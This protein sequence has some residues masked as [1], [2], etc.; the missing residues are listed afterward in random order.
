MKYNLLTK[1]YT[2]EERVPYEYHREQ[3]TGNSII[4]KDGISLVLCEYKSNS[5]ID[6]RNQAEILEK[7]GEVESIDVMVNATKL[8]TFILE[9]PDVY[10]RVKAQL[11]RLNYD[12]KISTLG[13]Y[14]SFKLKS[15]KDLDT[16]ISKA[17]FVINAEIMKK[18]Q[19]ISR[20]GMI[21]VFDELIEPDWYPLV[22]DKIRSIV[23]IERL[24]KPNNFEV[25]S[26]N[27]REITVSH[28]DSNRIIK[29]LSKITG[30]PIVQIGFITLVNASYDDVK[31]NIKVNREECANE[32]VY[33][34]AQKRYNIDPLLYLKCYRDI[35]SVDKHIDNIL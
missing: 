15:S 11:E 28:V 10:N 24:K 12:I 17:M 6:I 3:S 20:R 9:I 34:L 22:I 14:I 26:E 25:E 7:Y 35:M 4:Y 5:L 19:L 30:K 27:L 13:Q 1:L 33:I 29:Y 31:N 16:I 8:D 21:K 2:M 18:E 23:I 32:I